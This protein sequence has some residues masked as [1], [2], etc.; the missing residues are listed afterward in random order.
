LKYIAPIVVGKLMG[1]YGMF[2]LLVPYTIYTAYPAYEQAYAGVALL[3]LM[4]V[5]DLTAVPLLLYNYFSKA[6]PKHGFALS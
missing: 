1:L 4:V 3:V 6:T 5:I 2:L